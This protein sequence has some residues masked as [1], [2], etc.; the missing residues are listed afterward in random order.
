MSS[1]DRAF[2]AETNNQQPS[3]AAQE[4]P[5]FN[6]S[7]GGAPSTSAKQNPYQYNHMPITSNSSYRMTTSDPSSSPSTNLQAFRQAA[8]GGNTNMVANQHNRFS[9]ANS[10]S[11][12]GNLKSSSHSGGFMNTGSSLG[13][14]RL[15]PRNQTPGSNSF[16]FG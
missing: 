11:H 16:A 3:G 6:H 9:H 8:S 4:Q 13:K 1:R 2:G 12:M 7:L 15:S 5:G 10:S 14:L